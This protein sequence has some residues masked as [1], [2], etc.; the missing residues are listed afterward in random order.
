MN[1]GNIKMDLQD[2]SASQGGASGKKKLKT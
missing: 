1:N 2:S